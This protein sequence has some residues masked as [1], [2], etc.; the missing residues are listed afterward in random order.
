MT[1]ERALVALALI[2]A[3]TIGV[4]LARRTSTPPSTPGSAVVTFTPAEL[5]A[6]EAARVAL[7]AARVADARAKTCFAFEHSKALP[8]GVVVTPA[9]AAQHYRYLDAIAADAARWQLDPAIQTG[10]AIM[11]DPATD[12]REYWRAADIVSRTCAEGTK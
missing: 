8:P 12:A 1:I 9:I 11:R 6:R 10:L 5:A 3:I 7:Q 2:F 4:A